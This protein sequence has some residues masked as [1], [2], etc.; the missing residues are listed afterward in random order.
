MIGFT[1]IGFRVLGVA[2]HRPVAG[3]KFVVFR[4]TAVGDSNAGATQP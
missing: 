2:E 3:L 1:S 4:V